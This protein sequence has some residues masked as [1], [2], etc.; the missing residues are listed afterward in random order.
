M[1]RTYSINIS[2]E[3]FI[4]DDDA[5]QLLNNYLENLKHAFGR[6]PDCDTLISDI[7]GR[8]AELFT[9]LTE[10]GSK[11]ITIDNV[12]D[13]IKR[14]GKPEEIAEESIEID[15]DQPGELPPP[16]P[17]APEGEEREEIA[18]RIGIHKRLYRDIKYKVLGGVCS[19]IANYFGIDPVWVRIAV[20]LLF[21]F[22]S[23]LLPI[24]SST[25]LIAYIIMWVI[26]PPAVTPVQQLEMY[27]KPVTIDNIGRQL[28]EAEEMSRNSSSVSEIFGIFAKI[29]MTAIGCG[30]AVIGIALTIAFVVLIGLVILLPF[31]SA[32]CQDMFEELSISPYLF[33][34]TGIAVCLMVAIPCAVLVW[35]CLSMY[36][37]K[38]SMGKGWIIS[39][40]TVWVLSIGMS[41]I[42]GVE[43]GYKPNWHHDTIEDMTIEEILGEDE[44]DTTSEKSIDTLAAEAEK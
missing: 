1:K 29:L 3:P 24:S 20:V 18:P 17:P 11:V 22:A 43:I 21:F 13:M 25:I 6:T 39:L 35:C 16:P 32:L 30:A 14:I 19:G 2:G 37:N 12:H 23:S 5:Y 27:G 42:G 44:K 10:T 9:V 28:S 31:N 38:L 36:S 7:E 33:I 26:V 15:I 40:I 41:V 8:I 34:V 4:I